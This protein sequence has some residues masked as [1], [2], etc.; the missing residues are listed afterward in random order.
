[1]YNKEIMSVESW[2]YWGVDK[3]TV[4]C[5]PDLASPPPPTVGEEAR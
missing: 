3:L 4:I 1:M 5:D 2:T